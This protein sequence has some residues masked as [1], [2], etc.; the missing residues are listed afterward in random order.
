LPLGGLI[1]G[2][3]PTRGGSPAETERAEQGARDM[4][5]E[6]IEDKERRGER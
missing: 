4:R 2:T 6:L 3:L 5:E 1:Y